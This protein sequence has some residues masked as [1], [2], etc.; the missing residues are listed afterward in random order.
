MLLTYLSIW[1][2]SS[3]PQHDK[4]DVE[5]DEGVINSVEYI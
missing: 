3:A 5:G 2:Y 1:K 4:Q